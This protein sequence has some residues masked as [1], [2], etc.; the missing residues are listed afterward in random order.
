MH[1][2]RG[3]NDDGKNQ[4]ERGTDGMPQEEYMR[5]YYNENHRCSETNTKYP[6]VMPVSDSDTLRLAVRYDHV[7]A[8]YRNGH[9]SNKSF[10]E[11]DAVMFDVDNTPEK[12]KP[13]IPPE[14]WVYPKDIKKAFPG[15][16]HYIVYS[17]NN[18]K[19]KD[20]YSPRPRFHVYFPI[21]KIADA[22][23][24]KAF[25][26]AVCAYFPAFD[27]NAKDA[28]RFFFGVEDP[29]VEMVKGESDSES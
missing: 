10:I 19:E 21:D 23:E 28:A 11:A 17:R 2:S 13:D 6:H 3:A 5:I 14:Q 27:R 1:S 4:N 7:S 29:Q 25:K 12:G 22:K 15:V 8:Y 16:P 26:D 18:M 9:R 24:Y 20:G